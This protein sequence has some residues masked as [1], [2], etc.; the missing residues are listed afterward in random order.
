MSIG[1]ILASMEMEK[2]C[3]VGI[4]AFR[5]VKLNCYDPQK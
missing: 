4:G 2:S 5:G 3:G 1:R